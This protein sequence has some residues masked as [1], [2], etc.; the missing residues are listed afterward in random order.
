MLVNIQCANETVYVVE[1]EQSDTYEIFLEKV[2]RSSSIPIDEI[3]LIFAGKIL[4]AAEFSSVKRAP[5][6]HLLLSRKTRRIVEPI[7]IVMQKFI[8][9]WVLSENCE[10]N[11]FKNNK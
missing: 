4:T 5:T 9:V 7:S 1:L 2:E 10:R 3:R 6:P 11:M 8:A